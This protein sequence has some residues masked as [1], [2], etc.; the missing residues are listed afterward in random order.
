V[1]KRLKEFMPLFL[2]HIQKTVKQSISKMLTSNAEETQM[3]NIL[4]KVENQEPLESMLPEDIFSLFNQQIAILGPKLQGEVLTSVVRVWLQNIQNTIEDKCDEFVS[5]VGAEEILRYPLEINDYNKIMLN[6][7]DC[8]S[9]TT[10][11]AAEDQTEKV[12]Q[13]FVETAKV[14]NRCIDKLV[15]SMTE[16]MFVKIEDAVFELLFT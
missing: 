14:V 5:R 10:Q 11:Y 7:N 8:K 1:T 6:L 3:K 2:Q 9:E 12:G 16:V 13:M 4:E 15:Q